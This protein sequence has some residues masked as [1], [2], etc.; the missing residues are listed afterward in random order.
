VGADLNAAVTAYA[1]VIIEG[2][3]AITGGNRFGR[4]DFP[5]FFAHFAA[6]GASVHHRRMF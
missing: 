2:Q 5:A 3:V 4:T 6:A 1:A